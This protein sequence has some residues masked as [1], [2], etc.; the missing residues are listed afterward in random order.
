MV[1]QSNQQ[2]PIEIVSYLVGKKSENGGLLTRIER[3]GQK[4]LGQKTHGPQ[5]LELEQ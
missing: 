1:I 2:N 3:Y 4:A 5:P